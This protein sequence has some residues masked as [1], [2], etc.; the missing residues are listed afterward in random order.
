LVKWGARLPIHLTHP[1]EDKRA[2]VIHAL[3]SFASGIDKIA[4]FRYLLVCS[5]DRI[6]THGWTGRLSGKKRGLTH[7]EAMV[8][9]AVSD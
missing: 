4:A 8:E 5:N 7:V 3:G 1:L 2:V 6:R 9:A